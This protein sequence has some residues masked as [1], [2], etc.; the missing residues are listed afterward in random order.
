MRW[1]SYLMMLA[2]VAGCAATPTGPA[3]TRPA[4]TSARPT[5]ETATSASVPPAPETRISSRTGQP[6][7]VPP[8]AAASHATSGSTS[9]QPR[10]ANAAP[11]AGIFDASAA[12]TSNYWAWLVYEM[13]SDGDLRRGFET[14]AYPDGA[15]VCGQLAI[16]TSIPIIEDTLSGA[17]G[18][19]GTGAAAIIKA[20][21]NALCPR[22]NQGYTTYFDR[23]VSSASNALGT[24]LPWSNNAVPPFYEVGYF[25]KAACE[26]LQ[27]VGSAQGLEVH[28]HTFRQ[29]GANGNTMAATFI[30][31]IPDDQL[32]RRATHHAVFSGCLGD[33]LKLNSY[34]TMA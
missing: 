20:A 30:Q 28:L 6:T 10:G 15:F 34:W 27:K 17:K 16:G 9:T 33:H 3:T 7:P 26:Y 4:P 1:C 29:G 22:Y 31:R 25:M 11:D 21:V 12:A 8:P 14:E 19:S 23:S 5:Q 32:L 18:W 2:L 13:N 24:A